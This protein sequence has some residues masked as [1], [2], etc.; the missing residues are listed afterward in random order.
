[1]I[2]MWYK[3]LG[4][5]FWGP[6]TPQGG[7]TRAL[8]EQNTARAIPINTQPEQLSELSDEDREKEASELMVLYLQPSNQDAPD[9]PVF[10]PVEAEYALYV[11]LL[12]D[13]A[14]VLSTLVIFGFISM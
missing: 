3:F 7:A 9:A 6:L 4:M 10:I 12:F 1:M 5:A 13:V 2:L 14:L 11:R 8:L